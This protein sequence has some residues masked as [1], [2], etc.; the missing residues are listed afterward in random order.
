MFSNT[1]K[2]CLFCF[3]HRTDGIDLFGDFCRQ[4]NVIEIIKKHFWFLVC[5]I[6]HFHSINFK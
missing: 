3:N 2:R 6:Q 4:Q 5:F 1:M